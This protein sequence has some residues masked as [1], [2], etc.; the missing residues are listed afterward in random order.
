MTHRSTLVIAEAGVNHN[1]D[2]ATA[3]SLVD[4][5]PSPVLTSSNSR[6]S[7]PTN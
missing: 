4:V 5:A 3:L 1:G 7:P 2:L 6:P